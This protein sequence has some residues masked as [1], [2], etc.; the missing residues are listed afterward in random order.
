MLTVKQ[1]S[2]DFM[3]PWVM[4]PQPSLRH[5]ALGVTSPSEIEVLALF[6]TAQASN[7]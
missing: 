6:V 4:K 3:S 7:T 1:S 2:E 5:Y